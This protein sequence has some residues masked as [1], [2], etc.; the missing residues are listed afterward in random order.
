MMA[1]ARIVLNCLVFR[2]RNDSA[3]FSACSFLTVSPS[4]IDRPFVCA[5]VHGLAFLL[6]RSCGR[7]PF[8]L[9]E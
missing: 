9:V 1:N 6:P 5:D 8:Q 7:G 3:Q 4:E 2:K